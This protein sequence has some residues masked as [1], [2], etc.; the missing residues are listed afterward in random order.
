LIVT[1]A[2]AAPAAPSRWP[3]I[4]LVLLTATFREASPSPSLVAFV[5]AGSFFGV[6]VPWLL[7]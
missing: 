4:D 1:I 5:S 3:I 7:T 6:P 2:S